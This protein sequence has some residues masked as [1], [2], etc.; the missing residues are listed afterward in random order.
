MSTRFPAPSAPN[1]YQPYVLLYLLF[2]VLMWT[3]LMA[4][5]HKAPDLD[6]MEELVWSASFELGYVKHPPFPSWIMAALTSVFGRPIWLTFAAGMTASALGLWFI[7]KLAC[8]FLNPERALMVLLISSVSI[9]FSLRGT[10]FNH[11]TAQLWSVTAA[12]WFFYRASRDQK[13]ADWLWLGAVAALSTVTKYSAVILFTAFFLYFLRSGMW[14]QLQTWIGLVLA[15]AA[16]VLVLSPHLYWLAQHDFAPFR[17]MDGSLE[18]HTRWEAYRELLAFSLDQ[19]GRLSPMLVALIALAVWNRRAQKDEPA[20][21]ATPRSNYRYAD[22]LS[23]ADKQFLLWVGLTPIISTVLISAILGT[24]LVASW[25]T[26]FF[27][28][29]GFFALWVMHGREKVQLRRVAIIVIVLQILLASGYALARGPL[30]WQKGRDSRSTFPGP[31]VSAQMQSIW[32]QHMPGIPLKVV[33]ADTWLGGNIAVHAGLDVMVFIDAEPE[34]SPWLKLPQDLECG[35]LIV[36][37]LETR[38]TP[39]VSLLELYEHAP[40]KG[41]AEQRWSSERSPMIDLNWAILPAKSSC[42]YQP[43]EP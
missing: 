13:L 24:R 36:Y 37:S 14:R 26:T 11:N 42:P 20:T 29:F 2:M 23:R 31:E 5:S 33:V 3:V 27:V 22:D 35:A 9:Y 18:T 34:S 17:Y 15:L 40:I 39:P 25:A 38:G 41:L 10:I 21:D 12:T 7:W 30:A 43:S 4:I 6:G 8:E 32:K 1:T 16:Y 19:L 28:L